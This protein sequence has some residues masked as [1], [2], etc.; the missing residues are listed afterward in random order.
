MRISVVIPALNEAAAI[1]ECLAAIPAGS[2]EVV[3][4]DGGST[5]G[6][7]DAAARA[8]A[9]VVATERGRGPQMNAGASTATGDALLFLHADSRL[10]EDAFELVRRSLAD[11]AVAGGAF[12]LAIDGAGW[13]YSFTA[14]N[15]NIRSKLVGAPYGDQAFF[16]RRAAFEALG[17]YRDL[18]WC[19]DLDFIRRLRRAGR[20]VIAPGA[21]WTSA[22]RWE[23]HGRVRVTVRNG[24]LF[25]R[26]WLGLLEERKTR[27]AERSAG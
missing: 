21:V 18:P 9:R 25:L 17:G 14:R 4:A 19:E 7:P 13:F 8:G 1:G 24:L 20:V 26:Y 2:D 3:V 12:H 6:T 27:Q 11:E 23:R 22:R 5:D 10:P 16:V 15:A